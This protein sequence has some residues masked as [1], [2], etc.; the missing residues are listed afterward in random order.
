MHCTQTKE[1][2]LALTLDS[3]CREHVAHHHI[4]CISTEVRHIRH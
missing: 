1:K 2:Q 3:I 4:S